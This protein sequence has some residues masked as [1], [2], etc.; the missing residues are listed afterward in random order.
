MHISPEDLREPI[1]T[2]FG[3]S[4]PLADLIIH[5]NF[6]GNRPRGFES[7]RGRILPFSYLQAVAVN[8]V[9]ALPRSLWLC[10]IVDCSL[11]CLTGSFT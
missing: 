10:S 7:V 11:N 1:S 6:F 8:T 9:L 5:A 4:G 3:I 2:K